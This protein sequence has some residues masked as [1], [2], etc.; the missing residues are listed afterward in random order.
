[1]CYENA[2]RNRNL[3]YFLCS[4]NKDYHLHSIRIQLNPHLD[5]KKLLGKKFLEDMFCMR[6]KVGSQEPCQV[7]FLIS[8]LY[9]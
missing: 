8:F 3:S 1:M 2:D 5:C 4:G 9:M 7:T 6:N